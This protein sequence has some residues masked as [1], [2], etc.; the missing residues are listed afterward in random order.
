MAANSTTPAWESTAC[1]DPGRVRESNED[2]VRID[3]ALGLV[4][5]CDG[6]GGHASGE[7]ASGLAVAAIHRAVAQAPGGEPAASLRSALVDA[8]NQIHQ[9]SE[10]DPALRGMGTTAVAAL[11]GKGRIAIAWAG[12]SRAYR[13]RA[14]R[15]E[16]RTTDHS[17]L[18][19][20]IQI[21]QPSPEE[22]AR[23]PLKNVITRSLGT[24]PELEPETFEE[25]VAPGDLYL[26]CTDGLTNMVVDE[27]IAAILASEPDLDA[28]CRRL[29]DAANEAG[30]ADNIT[31]ALARYR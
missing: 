16:Q 25:V 31:V 5:V 27:A 28:A 10:A 6:M 7:V 13:Y 1:S 30:G 14:G 26:L 29:V 2:A 12:D 21:R 23:F 22:I 19:E 9:R 15:L 11:L 18:Q 3:P 24:E 8:S 17:L 20:F 4:C